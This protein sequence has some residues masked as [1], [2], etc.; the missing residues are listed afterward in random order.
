MKNMKAKIYLIATISLILSSCLGDRDGEITGEFPH[1]QAIGGIAA[2]D[3][4]MTHSLYLGDVFTLSPVLTLPEG[5]VEADYEFRWLVGKS[6]QVS[7]EKDLEWLIELPEGYKL[8]EK[9]PGVFVVRHKENGLEFRKTFDMKIQTGYTPTYM[10]VYETGDGTVDWMSI[11]GENPADFTRFFPDM[12]SRVN[13]GDIKISGAFRGAMNSTSELA[14]FTDHAPDFGYCVSMIDSDPKEHGFDANT[15]ELIAPIKGRVY[16]GGRFDLDFRDVFYGK[17][18]V[19]YIRMNNGVHVFDRTASKL[20]VF[21]ENTSLLAQDVVKVMSSKQ[22]MQYKRASLIRY[23]DGR[24]GCFQEYNKDA[25]VLKE[26]DNTTDFSL[27]ELCGMFSE[28]T[29]QGSNKPYKMYV[30]GKVGADYN[31]YIFDVP[32]SG[33]T[34]LQLKMVKKIQIPAEIGRAAKIWY[35]AYG[36]KYGFYVTGNDIKKFD[37]L[38]I[39]TFEPETIPFRTYPSKYEV[40]DVFVQIAGTGLKDQDDCTV[41]YLYDKVKNTTTIDVFNT[42]TGADINTYEDIIPGKGKWF[43]KR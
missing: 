29:G 14:I 35:G 43:L 3:G 22:F 25:Y 28:Q 21:D 7:A 41:V 19:K 2:S 34:A 6:E 9:I 12:V 37:Y 27:D 38:N 13:G 33:T 4:T 31:L 26:I 42:T 8:N 16:M 11:Q 17:S 39:E 36:E 5:S 18:G 15:G 24:I 23:T 20:P 1:V 10:A 32:Y 30:V 40:L